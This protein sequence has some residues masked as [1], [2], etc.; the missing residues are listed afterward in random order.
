MTNAS[1]LLA[2]LL[3]GAMVVVGCGKKTEDAPADPNAAAGTAAVGTTTAA[4]PTA[5]IT[6]VP[7]ATVKPTVAESASIAACCS[8]LHSQASAAA[9]MDKGKYDSAAKACDGIAAS[10]KSGATTKAGALGSIRAALGGKAL[11]SSCN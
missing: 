2:C 4:A 7:T 10:V 6:A 1:R 11:P 8:A 3:G 9:A 5:T